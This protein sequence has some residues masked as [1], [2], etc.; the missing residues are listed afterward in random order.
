MPSSKLSTAENTAAFCVTSKQTANSWIT[1]LSPYISFTVGTS[2]RETLVKRSGYG[3][4][5]AK[6]IFPVE[7][8]CTCSK[9]SFCSAVGVEMQCC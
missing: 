8:T 4:D 1:E 6:E 2:V 3:V 9:Y 7:V 5:G